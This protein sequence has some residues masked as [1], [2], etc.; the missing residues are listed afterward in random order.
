MEGL[1]GVFDKEEKD[2]KHECMRYG[3]P[4]LAHP[5]SPP[6]IIPLFSIPLHAS[7]IH[8]FIQSLYRHSDSN[9]LIPT[10]GFFMLLVS[11]PQH[12]I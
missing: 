12:K 2:Y 6:P 10:M 11:H 1:L 3:L 9:I 7:L 5:S 4:S 8:P